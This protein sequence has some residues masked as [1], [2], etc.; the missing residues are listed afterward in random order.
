MK[1]E[2]Y[3][4]KRA[5]AEAKKAYAIGEVPIGAVLV[6]DGVIIARAH[7]EREKK[8]SATAHA[9]MLCIE[10]ACKRL[11]D[12]RLDGCEMFVTLEPCPMCAGAIINARIDRVFFGAYDQKAGA[13]ESK[14][15]ILNSGALNW[16]TEYLGG[17]MAEEC[18]DLI[19]NFFN[20][21]RVKNKTC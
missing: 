18:E 12:W 7:N 21:R 8:R 5:Y 19:K 4:M 14:F 13:A 15:S 11:S 6:K 3:Y 9:E 17:V 1:D 20:E 10:K 2:K 16:S